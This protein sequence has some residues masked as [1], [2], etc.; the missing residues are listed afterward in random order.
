MFAGIRYLS[1]LNTEWECWAV[2]H[3]VEIE[4]RSRAPIE[5]NSGALQAVAQEFGLT[6][7]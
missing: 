6:I 5:R 2:F 1:R 4:E 7:F 3:D